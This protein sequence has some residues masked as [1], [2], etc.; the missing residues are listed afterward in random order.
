[1]TAHV[2]DTFP[3]YFE[4]YPVERTV[5]FTQIQSSIF[6]GIT[7]AWERIANITIEA[8]INGTTARVRIKY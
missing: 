3:L 2:L 6:D 7:T 4:R 8:R 1:M 5:N